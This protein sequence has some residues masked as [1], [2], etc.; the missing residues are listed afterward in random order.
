MREAGRALG[1]FG[2]E[3][4]LIFA[5]LGL[6]RESGVWMLSWMI[7]RVRSRSQWLGR[8]NG[9]DDERTERG[10]AEFRF[11]VIH[12]REGHRQPAGRGHKRQGHHRPGLQNCR[13]APCQPEAQEREHD[14]S[15]CE[16]AVQSIVKRCLGTGHALAPHILRHHIDKEVQRAAEGEPAERRVDEDAVHGAI[17]TSRA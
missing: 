16:G 12:E 6:M 11:P 14:L 7:G 8:D 10:D 5:F 2:A 3:T 1:D 4:A 15:E 13:C 9:S 17:R